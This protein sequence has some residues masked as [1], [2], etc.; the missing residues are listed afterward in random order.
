[1]E[2]RC[3]LHPERDCIGKAAAAELE[4]RIKVL[5]EWKDGSKEF[6][7]AVNKERLERAKRDGQIDV[8]LGNIEGRI[9]GMDGK[10]DTLL[11]KPRKR[12]EAI[13]AAVISAV[14]AGVVGFFL[15]GVG[16]G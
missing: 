3:I 1:M 10:L 11:E 13:V 4:G 6:H 14:V 2:E 7:D 15:A 5:E 9:D 8:R 16:V 12:W